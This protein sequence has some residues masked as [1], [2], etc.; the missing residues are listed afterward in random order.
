[1]SR[2][3][4]AILTLLVGLAAPACGGAE[5]GSAVPAGDPSRWEGQMRQLFGDTIHPA[6]VG[7]SM[8]GVSPAVDQNLGARAQHGDIVARVKVATVTSDRMGERTV[9][10]LNILVGEPTLMPA[11]L[12][13]R[14]LELSIPESNPSFQ[15]VQA[16]EARLSGMTLIGFFRRFTGDEGPEIHWYLTADTGEVAQAVEQARALAEAAGK[17]GRRGG[18]GR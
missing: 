13:D 6:A 7:L 3:L 11:K 8:D 12:P 14:S 18:R 16:N 17:K 10:H 2:T 4:C 1:M 9:Y 5:V 15:L